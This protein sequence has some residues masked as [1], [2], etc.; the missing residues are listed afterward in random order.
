MRWSTPIA[1]SIR[2]KATAGDEAL[3]TDD[4]GTIL[5][6]YDADDRL[7]RAVGSNEDIKVEQIIECI[8]EHQENQE[9][10]RRAKTIRSCAD[11]QYRRW[12][13]QRGLPCQPEA[14]PMRTESTARPKLLGA[15]WGWSDSSGQM[16]LAE[17]MET[18]RP[19]PWSLPNDMT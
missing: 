17:E 18:R 13:K 9:N 8:I 1:A 11:A 5:L 4:D 15:L 3:M 12:R 10:K 14:P 19:Y 6:T 2:Y 16:L 7:V